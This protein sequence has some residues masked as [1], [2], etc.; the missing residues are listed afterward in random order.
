MWIPVAHALCVVSLL[1]DVR[2]HPQN[3]F[4]YMVSLERIISF[5]TLAKL[6]EL[7]RFFAHLD[8]WKDVNSWNPHG[9]QTTAINFVAV[10]D[11]AV[12]T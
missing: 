2:K 8:N 4:A 11:N 12:H 7:V 5:R 1:P 3:P 10:H 6:K 9:N